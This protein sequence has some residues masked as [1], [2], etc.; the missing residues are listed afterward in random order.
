METNQNGFSTI[1]FT[2]QLLVLEDAPSYL[3][4]LNY[5]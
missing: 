5:L 4:Y 3:C 1:N 2:P